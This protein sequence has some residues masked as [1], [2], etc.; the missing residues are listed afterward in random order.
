MEEAGV[1]AVEHGA[2][3]PVLR[4]ASASPRRRLIMKL[5]GIPCVVSPVDVPEDGGKPG[6][7]PP[8]VALANAGRKALASA[9]AAGTE[10]P[11]WTLGADTIVV[12]GD[13]ILGKPRDEDEARSMIRDLSG[14][15]HTVVTA[16]ALV[17]GGGI[18]EVGHSSTVVEFRDLHGSRI[19]DY[20][21]SMEWTDKAGGYAIQGLGA[22]LIRAIEGD[23]FNVMGLPIGDVV[24]ALLGRGVIPRHPASRPGG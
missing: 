20:V 13:R 18:V 24:D 12:L 16:W 9:G 3:V 8:A 7:A 21:G 5:A 6:D 23:P 10:P 15:K 22:A 11:I 17:R 14:R 4:L 1:M 19:D 2:I